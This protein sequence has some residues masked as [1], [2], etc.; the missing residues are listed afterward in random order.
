MKKCGLAIIAVTLCIT[1][2]VT[3]AI[4]FYPDGGCPP[5]Q[6]L[7]DD[8]KKC[9]GIRGK[10]FFFTDKAYRK[11]QKSEKFDNRWTRLT[12]SLK[13]YCLLTCEKV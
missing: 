4:V 9:V 13:E 10:Y 2:V 8:N 11:I 5:G 7:S 3:L 12:Y 6:M 1:L